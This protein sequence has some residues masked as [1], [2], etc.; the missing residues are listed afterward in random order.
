[1]RRTTSPFIF[2][3]DV[4][5]IIL[6]IWAAPRQLNLLGRAVVAHRLIHKRRYA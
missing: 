2:L 6:S 5:L 3:L 1:M 4:G